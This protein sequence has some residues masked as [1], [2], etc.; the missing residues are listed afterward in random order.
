MKLLQ[1]KD[2]KKKEEKF[3]FISLERKMKR[4]REKM[5]HQCSL[6]FSLSHP[7]YGSRGYVP[8][9]LMALNVHGP[10]QKISSHHYTGNVL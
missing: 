5:R 3:Y 4:E 7:P 2:D 10:T 1:E 9:A 8:S 6:A